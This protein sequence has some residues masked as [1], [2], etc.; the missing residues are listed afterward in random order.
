MRAPSF[1]CMNKRYVSIICLTMFCF[2]AGAQE[3][4]INEVLFNP[5]KDGFDYVELYNN[6]NDTTNLQ[7][8]LIANRNATNDLANLKICSKEEALLAPACFAVLCGNTK[9]LLQQYIVPENA[10]VIQCALPSFPDDEG[11]IIIASKTDTLIID[12]LNYSEKWHFELI[13][14]DEGVSL[15]RINYNIATNDQQ[16]W[17]SASSASNF[18]SPGK[19]NSQRRT[20]SNTGNILTISPK[21]FSPDNNGVDDYLF[22][23]I[24]SSSPGFVANATVYDVSGR[25]VKYLL[26]NQTL[27]SFSRFRW[28]GTDD[29]QRKVSAGAYIIVTHIFNTQGSTQ[30]FKNLIVVGR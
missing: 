17:T 15:E 9:W 26:K 25:K 13:D 3:L 30:K 19:E 28:N 7:E 21:V 4:I 16:N 12:E 27:G 20:L 5:I 23:D 2:R 6:G 22:V 1:A 10:F 18:A 14:E 8:F 24:L 29:Y 11:S